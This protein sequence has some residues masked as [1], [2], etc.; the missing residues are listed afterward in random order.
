[1][2]RNKLLLEHRTWEDV[3]TL[4][5]GFMLMISPWIVSQAN[6]G[7]AITNA[8]IAG[9]FLIL[10]AGFEMSRLY[11]WEE[12]AVL[13]LGLWLMI[14]PSVLGYMTLTPLAIVH[15]VIGGLVSALAVLQ[16]WQDWDYSDD[17]LGERTQ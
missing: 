13:L 16:L 8:G 17:E 10:L 3:A 1:M 6:N 7:S 15:Q 12:F 11:R 9:F 4:F 5:L 14:S 2:A